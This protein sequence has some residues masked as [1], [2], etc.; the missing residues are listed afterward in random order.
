MLHLRHSTTIER[1]PEKGSRIWHLI[2]VYYGRAP[3]NKTVSANT[4]DEAGI[5]VRISMPPTP[6]QALSGSDTIRA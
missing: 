3:R 6:L 1:L 5:P 2:P 4:W